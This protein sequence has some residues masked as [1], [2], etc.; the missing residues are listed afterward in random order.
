[1][2]ISEPKAVS[3]LQGALREKLLE[4]DLA[5]Q[6]LEALNE[7]HAR[8]VECRFFAHLTIE[9]TATAIGVS[10]A[11]VKREWVLARA[12]LNRELSNKEQKS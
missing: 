2:K 11:T 6:R 3:K 9:E 10:P 12:W 4:L 1:M 8:I 5:L 7:R